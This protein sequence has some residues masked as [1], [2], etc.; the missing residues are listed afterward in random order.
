MKQ[1]PQEMKMRRQFEPGTLSKSGF[2]GD[3]ARHIHDIVAEDERRLSERGLSLDSVAD[4]LQSLI[5]AGK[6]GLGD[7]VIVNGLEVTVQWDRGMGPCPFGEPGLYPKITVT[8]NRLKD[9]ASMQFSQLSVH[10]IRKHGFF[11]G[12]GSVY[13]VEIARLQ[14]W[15]II[16]TEPTGH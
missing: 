3:D 11:G 13:R 15:G 7:P 4:A 16:T 14:Q 9:G 10:L 6:S 12:Q 1:T 8:V 2:L 5:N